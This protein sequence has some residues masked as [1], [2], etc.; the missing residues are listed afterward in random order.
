MP[1]F[2]N[3]FD[4]RCLVLAQ[5]GAQRAS[6]EGREGRKQKREGGEIIDFGNRTYEVKMYKLCVRTAHPSGQSPSPFL[7]KKRPVSDLPACLP[8]ARTSGSFNPGPPHL[9]SLPSCSHVLLYGA[10]LLCSSTLL[11]AM[12]DKD[13]PE[14][15]FQPIGWGVG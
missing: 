14:M 9:P 2:Y 4:L 6:E 12:V 5:T 15:D 7:G 13:V 3:S 8:V 10:F 1:A 11:S